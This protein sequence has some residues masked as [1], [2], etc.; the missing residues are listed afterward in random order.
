MV[1]QPFSGFQELLGEVN[2]RPQDRFVNHKSYE[3][4]HSLDVFYCRFKVKAPKEAGIYRIVVED[5]TVYIGRAS[6]L[7]NRLSSQYGNVSPRHPFAGGQ[8]QK[9]RTNAKINE[10]LCGGKR[11]YVHWEVCANYIER[12]R[13]LLKDSMNRPMWNLR[14]EGRPGSDLVQLAD[15]AK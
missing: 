10:A 15:V 12:E 14:G 1:T 3:L 8:L 5:V 2:L 4:H 6:N 13:D 9:C 11:V 7:R